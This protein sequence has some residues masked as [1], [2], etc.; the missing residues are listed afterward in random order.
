MLG[1]IPNL[2]LAIKS[3]EPTF[4]KLVHEFIFGNDKNRQNRE[5]VLKFEALNLKLMMR[6]LKLN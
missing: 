3:A 4:I 2:R 6:N 1:D 5:N